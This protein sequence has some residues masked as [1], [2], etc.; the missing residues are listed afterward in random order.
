MQIKFILSLQSWKFEKELSPEHRWRNTNIR[1]PYHIQ[2]SGEDKKLLL[3]FSYFSSCIASVVGGLMS[4]QRSLRVRSLNF[5]GLL[6]SCLQWLSSP[7]PRPWATLRTGWQLRLAWP[8]WSRTSLPCAH[9]PSPRRP[10]MPG[11]LATSSASKCLVTKII[12]SLIFSP[13]SVSRLF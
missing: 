10:R 5:Y 9:T 1:L 8:G 7:R 6:Y 13:F 3:N 11:C 4:G 2:L 12:H